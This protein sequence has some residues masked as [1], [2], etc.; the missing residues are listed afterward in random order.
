MGIFDNISKKRNGRLLRKATSDPTKPKA[1]SSKIK[2]D[3]QDGLRRR[4]VAAALA[5]FQNG[6]TINAPS[7]FCRNLPAQG[8]RVVVPHQYF[9]ITV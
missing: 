2:K 8:S 6:K 4:S 5:L 3:G 7:H 1:R 9:A